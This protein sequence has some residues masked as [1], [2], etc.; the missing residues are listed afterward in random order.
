MLWTLK[1]Q[2]GKENFFGDVLLFRMYEIARAVQN[3]PPE[4]P[5]KVRDVGEDYFGINSENREEKFEET[6]WSTSTCWSK[7]KLWDLPF[8]IF[9][10]PRESIGKRPLGVVICLIKV[11]FLHIITSNIDGSQKCWRKK[12]NHN[13]GNENSLLFQKIKLE[14]WRSLKKFIGKNIL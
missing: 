1:S 10:N 14:L 9:G 2:E 3:A 12:K 7:W 5:S 4:S 11:E 8:K 6:S 13:K